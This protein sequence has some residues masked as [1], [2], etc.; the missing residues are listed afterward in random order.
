MTVDVGCILQKI[1]V[2]KT[3]VH[4]QW[5][6]V[7]EKGADLALLKLEVPVN[8]SEPV[9]V[10]PTKFGNHLAEQEL[11]IVGWGRTVPNG[12][13][14]SMLRKA[15]NL[16]YIDRQVC[17]KALEKRIKRTFVCAGNGSSDDCQGWFQEGL[18]LI[19]IG[20]SNLS[21]LTDLLNDGKSRMGSLTDS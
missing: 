14:A 3:I 6:G 15:E 4:P 13:F 8:K 16:P 1:Q 18:G 20:Y 10:P 12:R 21:P 7:P 9:Q 17:G 19:Q 11:T 5:K 2:V